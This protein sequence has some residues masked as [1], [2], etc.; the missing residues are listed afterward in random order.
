MQGQI[1]EFV[2]TE[3]TTGA[4]DDTPDALQ[5][6]CRLV[7]AGKV[8]VPGSVLC[9]QFG[10]RFRCK[11]VEPRDCLRYRRGD[12]GLRPFCDPGDNARREVRVVAVEDRLTYTSHRMA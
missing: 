5:E 8:K 6:G 1:V 7:Q 10:G 4:G 12:P 3:C 2:T 9:G 11:R